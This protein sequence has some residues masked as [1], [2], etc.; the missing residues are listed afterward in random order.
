MKRT[1]ISLGG[2]ILV[3]GEE[4]ADFIK[5]IRE[6]I[7]RSGDEH[8]FIIITGGGRTARDYIQI[9]RGINIQVLFNV[10]YL[11]RNDHDSKAN[12][13]LVITAGC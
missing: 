11:L 12:P 10:F 9:G 8:R 1:V 2:S 7:E 6:L 13:C 5:G 3:K 4:D